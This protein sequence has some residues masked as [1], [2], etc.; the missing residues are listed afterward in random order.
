L[1]PSALLSSLKTIG[2]LLQ[3]FSP[4]VYAH[5]METLQS[6]DPLGA[7]LA[8]TSVKEV[9]DWILRQPVD[10]TQGAYLLTSDS[11]SW[12]RSLQDYLE[13]SLDSTILRVVCSYTHC[14]MV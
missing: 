1:A 13:E 14:N 3:L 7:N 10:G 11:H 5:F 4:I 8:F 6:T 2:P 9:H 12:E